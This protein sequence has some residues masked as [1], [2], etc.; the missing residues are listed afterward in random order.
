MNKYWGNGCPICKVVLAKAKKTEGCVVH[1]ELC[2]TY[3]V[4]VDGVFVIDSIKKSHN[5]EFCYPCLT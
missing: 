1:C 4:C 2:D 5:G 3:W